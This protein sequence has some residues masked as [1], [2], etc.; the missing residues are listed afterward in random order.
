MKGL[1]L[2]L[3]ATLAGLAML[4]AGIAGVA[5]AFDDD[6]KGDSKVD[7]TNFSSCKAADP[8]L[9]EFKS[10]DLTGDGGNASV[11]VTCEG[12]VLQATML[13]TGLPAEKDRKL[14]LWVYR[15]RRTAEIVSA[16]P[17]DAG[18]P[19]AF[20]SGPIPKDTERYRKW[21]VTEEPYSFDDFPPAPAGP[22]LAQS[23]LDAS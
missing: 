15:N 21:V 17:Q 12:G 23:P 3:L 9:S 16:V 10:F 5:G 11:L 6:S 13:G 22:I 14:A 2:A 8:R 4:A 1:M 7:V 20:L 18:E 19:G